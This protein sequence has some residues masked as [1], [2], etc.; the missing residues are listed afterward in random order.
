MHALS[1]AVKCFSLTAPLL[2]WC[3]WVWLT[4]DWQFTGSEKNG[5]GKTRAIVSVQKIDIKRPL[6]RKLDKYSEKKLLKL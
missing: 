3:N 1:C 4:V 5:L 6:E 2:W